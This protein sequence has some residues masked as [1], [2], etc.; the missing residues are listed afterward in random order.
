MVAGLALCWG[1]N[2]PAIKI[3]LGQLPPF[4]LRAVGLGG[5]ALLLLAVAAWQR[6]RLTLPRATWGSN[7]VA[8][9]LTIVVFNFCTAFAQLNTTTSRAAVLTY[10]MPTLSAP[11]AWLLL[12]E[13]PGRRGV[14]AVAC[15]AAGIGL[16]AWPALAAAPGSNLLGLVFALCA[17]LAWALGTIA[18]KRAPPVHDRVVATAWQLGFG[19]LCGL[20]ASWVAGEAWPRSLSAP[21]AWAL[22]HHVVLAMAFAY[23]LWYRLL[24]SA[25]AT[26]SSLTTL[27][28][29]VV[30]VLGAMALVG[31]RPGAADWLGFVLVLGAAA[32]VLFRPAHR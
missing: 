17:A 27:A 11:L 3:V 28:V 32:L 21:V 15:G 30:G 10:T 25:T 13:R 12:G 7:A 5:G 2:W 24:D 31:D 19:G 1:L 23:V 29:P 9:L 16:L 6:R 14:L 22:A 26:V 18:T 4:A 20:A 8:G